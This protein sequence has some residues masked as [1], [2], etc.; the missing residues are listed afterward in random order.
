MT[1]IELHINRADQ[2]KDPY[3]YVPFTVPGG[4]TRI[5]VKFDTQRTE[6]VPT[7]SRIA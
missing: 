7:R 6:E 1:T 4:T 2:A 5:D 3:L